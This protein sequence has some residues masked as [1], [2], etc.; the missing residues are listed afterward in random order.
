MTDPGLPGRRGPRV[1]V[2]IADPWGSARRQEP[3]GPSASHSK[4]DDVSAEERCE[5]HSDGKTGRRSR[6]TN[7]PGTERRERLAA[8][9]SSMRGE[10]HVSPFD[11]WRRFPLSLKVVPA[12]VGPLC[13]GN[14]E[15]APSVGAPGVIL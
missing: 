1:A 8:P 15:R 6:G 10:P 14:R 9:A 11:E 4:W 5:S 3:A 13:P 2:S 12:S 7:H